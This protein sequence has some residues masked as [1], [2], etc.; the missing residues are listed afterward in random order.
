MK[1]V[2]TMV[3]PNLNFK[4]VVAIVFYLLFI[5]IFFLISQIIQK[6]ESNFQQVGVLLTSNNSVLCSE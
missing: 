1:I 2:V 4:F 5:Y 6:Q 3:P